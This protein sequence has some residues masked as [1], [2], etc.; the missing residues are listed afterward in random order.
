MRRGF[1]AEAERIAGQVREQ[2]GLTSAASADPFRIAEHMGITV[3]AADELIGRRRLEELMEIQADA[4][5]AATFRLQS[6]RL[7]VITNPLNTRGESRRV[8]RRLQ[9]LR[10]WGHDKADEV[11][12][13]DPGT[14]GSDGVRAAA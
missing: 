2:M 12:A 9:P 5:S 14:S 6:G 8:I 7:V 1:K 10:G 3:R 4:F 13:G 11:P